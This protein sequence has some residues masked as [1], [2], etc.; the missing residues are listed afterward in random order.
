MDEKY[1]P[2]EKIVDRLDI[3]QGDIIFISSDIKGLVWECREH[4]EK[5]DANIFI[6]SILNRIGGEGTLIFPTYN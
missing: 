1:I 6:D 2:Y 4:G 3:Q 5:F